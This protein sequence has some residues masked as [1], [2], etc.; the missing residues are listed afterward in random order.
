[1]QKIVLFY[2]RLIKPGGAERLLMKEYHYFKKMG[3]L[4]QVVCFEFDNSSLFFSNI[5]VEDL[6]VFKKKYELSNI[7]YLARFI[8]QTNNCK[9]ICNSGHV[10]YYLAN[11]IARRKYYL[12]LHQPSSMSINEYDKFSFFKRKAFKEL[13][14]KNY[15]ASKFINLKKSF[16]F[17]KRLF[18]NIR[19]LVSSAAISSAKLV[20][21]LSDYAVR[22]KK[23]MYGIQAVNISG[24]LE[25]KVF[26]YK[27]KKIEEFGDYKNKLL[28][29]ARL[30]DK[31]KRIDLLISAFS[32]FLKKNPD[33]ILV[34]GG[35][36]NEYQ[37]LLSLSIELK[38]ET[39]VKFVG[40]IPES[41][42]YDYYAWTDLFVSIDWADFR[43]TSY[44]ALAMGKK[45][46]LSN[47]TD[48][49]SDLINTGYYYLTEPSLNAVASNIENALFNNNI[50][51]VIELKKILDKYTWDQYFLR[52][53]R[54]INV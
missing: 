10:S 9:F 45:V 1:M 25:S 27:P 37:N 33:S 38:I 32:I 18:I 35:S 52:M 50:I 7:Y 19:S 14:L 29:V 30:D 8:K 6:F 43:I 41:L 34:I 42:L 54:L 2:K 11:L 47:E 31:D 17:A 12:H 4:T 20:F 36:G 16:G 22:E 39:H 26:N 23:L 3:Y 40:F 49:D 46:L 48:V 15:G 13:V 44:E 51:T 5:D 28:T 24:A 53:E 21:V